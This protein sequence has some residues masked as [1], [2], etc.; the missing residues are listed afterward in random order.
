[1]T[2]KMKFQLTRANTYRLVVHETQERELINHESA[3]HFD[4][5]D[6][7]FIYPTNDT[8]LGAPHRTDTYSTRPSK[9][10]RFSLPTKGATHDETALMEWYDAVIDTKNKG[11][12]E[13]LV[14]LKDFSKCTQIELEVFKT[15]STDFIKVE[16][17]KAQIIQHVK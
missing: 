3:L 4:D 7:F 17:R 12:A 11:Q 15:E 14:T 1:M 6:L 13:F 5:S 8:Q 10:K 9:K 16:A 2:S